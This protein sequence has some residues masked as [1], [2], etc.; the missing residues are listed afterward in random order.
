MYLVIIESTVSAL[1]GTRA[2]WRHLTRTGDVEVRIE[3]AC[4][5]YA[6]KVCAA[7]RAERGRE[8]KAILTLNDVADIRGMAESLGRHPIIKAQALNGLIERSGFY[9]DK[10]TGIWV[11]IRPDAIPTVRAWS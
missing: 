4:H 1:V 7:W 6:A 3:E 5:T 2:Q 8:G 10:D 11:K 9:K